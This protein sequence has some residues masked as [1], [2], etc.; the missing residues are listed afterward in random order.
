MATQRASP[1]QTPGGAEGFRGLGEAEARRA[2]AHR[3]L[4]HLGPQPGRLRRR[5]RRLEPAAT[6]ARRA[7]PSCV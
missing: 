6:T 5:P 2:V 1:M 7:A 4:Q 3:T